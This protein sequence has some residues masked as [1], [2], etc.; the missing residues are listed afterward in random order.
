MI[1]ITLDGKILYA[2]VGE[3]LSDVLMRY[4]IDSP[5]PCAGKGSCKKCR[6]L[7]DGKETLSCSYVL[8]RDVPLPLQ[9][10]TGFDVKFFANREG[11][12]RAALEQTMDENLRTLNGMVASYE[13]VARYKLMDEEFQ[14]TPKRSIK[15]Y[16]YTNNF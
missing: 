4:G 1:K 9:Q 2:E 5:H 16:L 12:D 7:V 11:I 14:K 6:V 15:R 10:G 8:K 3:R 13:K